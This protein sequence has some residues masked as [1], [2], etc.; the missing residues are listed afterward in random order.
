MNYIYQVELTSGAS[1]RR[2]GGCG[3]LLINNVIGN[4]E[5]LFKKQKL[6]ITFNHSLPVK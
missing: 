1:K 4:S 6:A 3:L 5:F 2:I